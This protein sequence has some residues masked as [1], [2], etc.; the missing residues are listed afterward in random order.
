MPLD[1]VA[2]LDLV[3]KLSRTRNYPLTEQG[4]TGF[5]ESLMRAAEMFGVDGAAIVQKCADTS[6]FCPTDADLLNIARD[7]KEERERKERAATPSQEAE[8]R[9]QYGPPQ[10][11]AVVPVR[12]SERRD[13][14]LWRK[15]RKKYP[16][17]GRK[18]KK[19]WPDLLTLSKDARELG[20]PDYADAWEKSVK[21]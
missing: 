16:N 11:F 8:W 19:D 2:A 20:Y 12:K 4:V 14:E 6:E 9:K 17:A 3:A 13:D 7:L 10:D 5:A 1:L 21:W 15:L 18:G